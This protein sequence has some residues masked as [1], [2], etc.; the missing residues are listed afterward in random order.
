MKLLQTLIASSALAALAAGAR[1]DDAAKEPAAAATDWTTV[2]T[3]MLGDAASKGLVDVS[4]SE[5][6]SY[7][8]IK[9]R[10][11]SRSKTPLAVDLAG[12]YLKSRTTTSQRLSIGPPVLTPSTVRRGAGTSVVLLEP[13]ATAEFVVN[14]CC[15]DA[16]LPAPSKQTFGLVLAPMPPV[17]EKVMRWWNDNPTAPQ[18]AVNAAIWQNAP[19]VHVGPGVVQDYAEP[20][21]R[22]TALHGGAYYRLVDGELTCLDEQGLLRVLAT[23]VFQVLPT[24][25]AVYAVMLGQ[26][27]KPKLWRL[28]VTGDERWMKITDLDGTDRIREVFEGG[29]GNL[30]IL[31]DKGVLFWDAA[32]SEVRQVLRDS[33]CVDP[34]ATVDGGRVVIA[35]RRPP[36]A[37]TFR[38]GQSI[39]EQTT[40]F[41]VWSIDMETGRSDEVRKFWNIDAIRAGAG[42][43]FALT[44]TERRL[45]RLNDDK[46]VD[47]G[48]PNTP[49][50]RIVGVSKETLWLADAD[51]K[52]V[53]ADPK[54][55]RVR[56]RTDVAADDLAVCGVDPR[57]GDISYVAGAEFRRL[58][59]ADGRQEGVVPK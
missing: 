58:F 11:E 20:K 47:I 19:D 29:K 37:P 5:P 25:G 24:D 22:F 51:G 46:F 43:I 18:S 12:A 59:A 40:V 33:V 38:G 54:T 35:C 6:R 53:A 34:T 27:G 44:P 52:L 50:R 28:A 49:Y 23:R 9:L 21:G 56:M 31:T 17:R 41:S 26:D 13:G 57:T 14:T 42:G 36:R 3:T 16:G 10:L 48:P 2:P 30:A 1:A 8:A 15:M 7:T 4:G 32:K 39:E 45:R 55:G